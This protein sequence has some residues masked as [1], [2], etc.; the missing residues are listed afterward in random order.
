[1]DRNTMEARQLSRRGGAM[2]V[3]LV[4]DRAH[5]AGTAITVAEGEILVPAD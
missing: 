5:L 1:L 4:G 3:T 2:T